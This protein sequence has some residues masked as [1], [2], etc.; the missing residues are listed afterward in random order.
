MD[1]LPLW[2][3]FTISTCTAL[4]IGL[5]AQLFV[6]PWQKRKILGMEKPITEKPST[7][8]NGIGNGSVITVSTVSTATM[9]APVIKQQEAEESEEQVNQ[10]FTFLQIL[11][12]I[13]SSFAHGGNDV[14]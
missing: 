7:M 8:E 1:K 4:V 6:V 10:L 3:V 12:A 14:R 2:L 9:N 5:V 11:A 13:F